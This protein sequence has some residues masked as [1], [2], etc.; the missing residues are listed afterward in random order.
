MYN[1]TSFPFPTNNR[2]DSI[3][4][5]D[6]SKAKDSYESKHSLASRIVKVERT[7]SELPP[8]AASRCRAFR[9]ISSPVEQVDEI[10]LKLDQLIDMYMIDR[11]PP[12]PTSDVHSP[13]QASAVTSI[14]AVSTCIPS[15]QASGKAAHAE[16]PSTSQQ[17]EE[18]R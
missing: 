6:G 1:W 14:S 4:G 18:H 16:R 3:L 11:R 15:E 10:E 12:A 2:L 13:A 5:K 9:L 8:R 7:V 17:Q